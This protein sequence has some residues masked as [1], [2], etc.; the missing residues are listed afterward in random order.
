MPALSLVVCLHGEGDLLAR[1]LEHAQGCYDDL[2]VVHDGP[3]ETGVRAIVEAAGGRF[4]ERPRAFQQEPHWPFAWGEARHDW[5]L[6]WD[7]DEFPSDGLR[8]WLAAFRQSQEPADDISGYSLILPLWDG[9]K[10]QTS[11]WPRRISLIHRGRVRYFGMAD[12]GPIADGQIVAL[13]HVLHHQPKRPSYGVWYTL[14]RPTSRRWHYEI[15]RSLLGRP[16]DLA[17]WRWN[18]PHWP[19][20]WDEIRRRPLA[21]GLKRLFLSPFRNARDMLRHGEFPRPSMLTFFPLQHWLTCYRFHQ[22]KRGDQS[23]LRSV[24]SG[25]PVSQAETRGP[26][27]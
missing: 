23:F 14:R 7:A 24:E 12:Q 2:V 21:T 13:P 17:C 16:T 4:F 25:E 5:I 19:P 15:A 6:R 1:Q 8:D 27:S 11:N 20:K 3:D 18:D 26:E 10:A 22:L 9:R